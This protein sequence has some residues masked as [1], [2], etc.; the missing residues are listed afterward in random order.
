MREIGLPIGCVDRHRDRPVNARGS[1]DDRGFDTGP[2]L[3]ELVHLV[4]RRQCVRDTP[5]RG[6]GQY[7]AGGNCL[8]LAFGD[9]SK[10]T[11]VA[12]YRDD[13]RHV[14]D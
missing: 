2:L 10:E 11:A 6:F 1:A 9:N 12:G 5:L 13:S 3:Q 14:P 4:H 7:F 8:L